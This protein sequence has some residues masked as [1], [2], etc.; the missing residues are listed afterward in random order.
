MLLSASVMASRINRFGA[1]H[2][3]D[4]NIILDAK[5]SSNTKKATVLCLQQYLLDS[6]T[7]QDPSVVHCGKPPLTFYRGS[8]YSTHFYANAT[9]GERTAKS[10]NFLH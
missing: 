4:M 5:D 10:T 6:E 7:G 8:L 9:A 1:L 3:V 2:E